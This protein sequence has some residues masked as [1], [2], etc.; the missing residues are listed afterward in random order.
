MGWATGYKTKEEIHKRFID[1]WDGM[2]CVEHQTAPDNTLWAVM[3][4]TEDH[5]S[6]P[7]GHRW[8][9]CVLIERVNGTDISNYISDGW[10]YK[11]MQESMGPHNY[12]C[13]ARF[14][15]MVPVIPKPWGASWRELVK[16]HNL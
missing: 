16:I 10:G 1:G 7:A 3:E 2:R 13:P 6:I 4:Y 14:L 8:I 5:E 15:D 11:D 9:L 12:S